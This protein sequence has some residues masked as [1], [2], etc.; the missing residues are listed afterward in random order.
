MKLVVTITIL[1]GISL[2]A[3]SQQTYQDVVYLRNGAIIRGMI[4]EQ[5]PGKSAKIETDNKEVF[6]YKSDEIR[7]IS[8]EPI[9]GKSSG[10]E[11]SSGL[12]SGYRGIA[13]IGYGSLYYLKAVKLNIINCIQFGQYFSVGLGTGLHFYTIESFADPHPL[14]IPIFADI[15][16]YFI[17]NVVTPYLSFGIGYSFDA[18]NSFKGYGYLWN[19]IFG[20]SLNTSNKSSINIGLGLDSQRVTRYTASIAHGGIKED[21]INSILLSLNAG[22][23]F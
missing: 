16:T 17:N 21:K 6:I 13:E 23:S 2:A 15:R 4:I 1:I 3:F 11:N 7:K 14:L 22:I 20:I 5:I 10:F 9:K 12:K 18:N 19:L 8:K